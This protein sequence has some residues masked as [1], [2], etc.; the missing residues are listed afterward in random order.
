MAGLTKSLLQGELRKYW[1]DRAVLTVHDGLL[2]RGTRLVIPSALRGD[3]LQRLHEGH[4]GVTKCR[5]R[6]KQTVW[7][8]GLSSQLNDMVLK[9]KTCIQ[10]RRNV[11]E[12][13]MPTEMPDRPWQTLGADLFTLKGKTY[14]LV[15]DYFSRYVEI[16]L[17]SP[18]RSEDVVV[19]L[20]SMF[21]RHGVCNYLKSD[22]G[23]QF[24][25]SHFKNFA[26]EY[27][28][29]HITS[30]PKFPQ[31]NGEAER[32]V[33]T[34]KHLLTKASDPYLALL[35]YRATPLQNGYSPAELLMGR[36]LRTT[37]PAL[38]TL[39]NPALPDYNALEAK[40][41]EKRMNDARSFDKRHGA[42]NLEPLVPGEDVWITDARVQGTVVS[43][44]NTPRS[45]LVQVPQG[46]LRRNRHHLVPLQTNSG[47]VNADE[48]VGEDSATPEPAPPPASTSGEDPTTETVRTRSGREVRQ[49][50]RLDL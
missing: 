23:P 24:Q 7:W 39:L 16:A 8:P 50:Q 15:V 30:S 5:N 17:L 4:M 19:H 41:R 13:L 21:S 33:Q 25:G 10:E 6:A 43:T 20:K 44:H 45:Y 2:L 47:V 22:N 38:P 28:F 1:P 36:R 35:A 14:L 46:T 48:Q 3:V 37:V 29:Q 40:E 31:S 18:T 11:K 49:P 42:R 12:P 34:V 9:C 27:G 32:A 26:A